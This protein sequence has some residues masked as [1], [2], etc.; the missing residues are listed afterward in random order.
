MTRDNNL[1]KLEKEIRTALPE[2]MELNY[3]CEVRV[4]SK[5][6]GA[7]L[8]MRPRDIPKIKP[9]EWEII[10]HPVTILHLLRWLGM[11]KDYLGLDFSGTLTFMPHEN[12]IDSVTI[13][14]SKPNLRD[15][16]DDVINELCKLI[17]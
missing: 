8:I 15:Q 7:S 1:Q 5:K 14:L 12:S 16:H 3:G 11:H 6:H 10:G 17:N 13:D 4:T 2:L 9:D